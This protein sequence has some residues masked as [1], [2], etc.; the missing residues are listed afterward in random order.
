[1]GPR[2]P[3]RIGVQSEGEMDEIPYA[4]VL[5]TNPDAVLA[6]CGGLG[7]IGAC[8][9]CPSHRLLAIGNRP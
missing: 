1:M 4:F 8:L 2:V 7:W 5:P 9:S 3:L 6:I